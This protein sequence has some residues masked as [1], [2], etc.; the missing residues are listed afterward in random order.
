MSR[1]SKKT[2]A[3]FHGKRVAAV[4]L[5]AAICFLGYLVL[6]SHNRVKSTVALK[7]ISSEGA[8]KSDEILA[9][10]F[11]NRLSNMKVSGRGIVAKVL[12]DDNFGNRHQRFII[13]L[14]SGQTLLVAHNIDI[15]SR[16]T[17]LRAGD[18]IRF[19][20]EYEWNDQGGVIH[21]TH[22]DPGG[23]HIGGWIEYAGKRYE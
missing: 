5:V 4:L 22:R 3:L 1:H 23:R 18:E 7:A 6:A 17:G 19:L 10:A 21:N 16:V 2:S 13:K 14:A 9:R 20:G 11:S 15:A 8:D 12:P